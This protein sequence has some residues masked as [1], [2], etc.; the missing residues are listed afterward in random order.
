MGGRGGKGTEMGDRILKLVVTLT[1]RGPGSVPDQA[2]VVSSIHSLVIACIMSSRSC[3]KRRNSTT[4]PVTAKYACN[5][6][7][8]CHAASCK[9]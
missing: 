3:A 5:S 4:S 1:A 2:W 6:D 8:D 7:S 9:A